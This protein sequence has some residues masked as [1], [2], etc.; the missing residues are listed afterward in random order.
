VP[1]FGQVTVKVQYRNGETQADLPVYAFLTGETET[2]SGI[3]G[4]TDVSG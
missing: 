2:Y 1:R 3:S 4:K